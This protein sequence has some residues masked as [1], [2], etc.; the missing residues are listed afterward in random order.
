[1]NKAWIGFQKAMIL[2]SKIRSYPE[3]NLKQT[4]AILIKQSEQN[5]CRWCSKHAK[6]AKHLRGLLLMKEI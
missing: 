1:M 6:R 2:V 4:K 3:K 5:C